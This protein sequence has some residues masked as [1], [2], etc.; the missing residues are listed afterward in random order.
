MRK[1][2]RLAYRYRFLGWPLLAA[3][4]S[5]LAEWRYRS[6]P[7]LP[8]LA[9]RRP[10]PSLSIVIPARNE[11]ANLR[12]LLPSLVENAYPGQLEVIVVDDDSGDATAV[13]VQ[14]HD[15]VELIRVSTLPEGWLGKPFACHLG[16]MAASGEWLLFS[17]ADTVHNPHGLAQAV[18]Y[19]QAKGLDAL[20]LWLRQETGGW[21]DASVMPVAFAGLFA[22]AT[23]MN[24]LLNGQYILL[25]REA[26]FQSGGFAAVSDEPVEDLALGHHLFASDYRVQT[27][28]GEAAA[29][30]RLYGDARGLWHGLTRLGGSSLRWL[31]PGS[32]LTMLLVTAAMSPILRIGSALTKAA[33]RPTG[34]RLRQALLAWVAT[35]PAFVLWARRFGSGWW[36]VLAPLGALLVQLAATWGLLSRLIGR[37]IQWKGRVVH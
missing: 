32:L 37:G 34:E 35:V 7:R 11:E 13:V 10:L 3:G 24:T 18:A 23:T 21:L 15:D 4:L 20:S 22:G 6:L 25:R 33:D 30:V 29:S 8:A 12:R 14:E 27:L 16:A 1:N 19:A 17:D 5:L 36:A 2:H 31:G 26:Y 28:R 9:V